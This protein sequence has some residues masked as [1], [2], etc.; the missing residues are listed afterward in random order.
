MLKIFWK[1]CSNFLHPIKLPLNFN[2]VC[3]FNSEDTKLFYDFYSLLIYLDGFLEI[4]NTFDG[5]LT[6]LLFSISDQIAQF[7]IL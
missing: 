4:F 6:D 2:Q 5:D 3:L 7:K 1:Y